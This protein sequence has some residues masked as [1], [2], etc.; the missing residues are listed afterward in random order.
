[1]GSWERFFICGPI[2]NLV[3]SKK[4]KVG[5]TFATPNIHYI[6]IKTNRLCPLTLVTSVEKKRALD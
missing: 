2:A 1:M 4:K 5:T 3:V 6:L